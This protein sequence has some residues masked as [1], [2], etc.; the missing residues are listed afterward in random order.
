MYISTGI[1]GIT[2]CIFAGLMTEYFHPKWCF[3]YYSF[4]GIVV[5]V[6]AC[7]LTKASEMDKVVGDAT[8]EVS[9][10]Q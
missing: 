7:R 6:T 8:T 3:F 2:G 10:S 4:F 5:S 9:S 1:G